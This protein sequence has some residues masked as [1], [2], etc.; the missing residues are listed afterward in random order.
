[1]RRDPLLQPAGEPLPFGAGQDAR[2]DVEGDDALLGLVL[3]VDRKGDADAAEEELG[4]QAPVREAL[5]AG[6]ID[7]ALEDAITG[8]AGPIG[9]GSFR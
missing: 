8:A 7:P 6:G 1:M 5:R 3:A 2:D 4:L 9:A